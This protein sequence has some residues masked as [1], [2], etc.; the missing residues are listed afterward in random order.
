MARSLPLAISIFK[1]KKP[2]PNQT[3][4]QHLGERKRAETLLSGICTL[5][6]AQ[7]CFQ[8]LYSHFLA[9]KIWALKC[10]CGT[11]SVFLCLGIWIQSIS[12]NKECKGKAQ[13]LPLPK[14]FHPVLPQGRNVCPLLLYSFPALSPVSYSCLHF[15]LLLLWPSQFSYFLKKFFLSAVPKCLQVFLISLSYLRFP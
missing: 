14:M 5:P 6:S 9:V 13:T 12:K 2:K 4:R 11:P 10:K 7:D 1:R 8:A 15:L 3:Q